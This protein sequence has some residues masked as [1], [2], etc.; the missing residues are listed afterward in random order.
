ML[1]HGDCSLRSYTLNEQ[2]EETAVYSM[3]GKCQELAYFFFFL[4]TVRPAEFLVVS[5]HCP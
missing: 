1:Q 2:V 4:L 5:T 3:W